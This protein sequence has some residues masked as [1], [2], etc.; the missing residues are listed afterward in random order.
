MRLRAQRGSALLLWLAQQSVNRKP[1]IIVV[2]AGIGGLTTT[3]CLQKNGYKV[4]VYEQV[5]ELSEIGA[6]IQTSANAGVVLHDLGLQE[7]LERGSNSP[8]TWYTRL[9][10]T[11]EIVKEIRL[12]NRHEELHGV[13]YYLLHRA[14]F[15]RMLVRKVREHD[16]DA[17]V[18]SASA[19]RIEETPLSISG[20]L[21][22]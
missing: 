14:D 15:H 19:E 13:P 12:G 8:L 16:P 4:K 11:D 2:G 3:A 22:Q 20:E 17:I 1:E 18:S 6:G 9:H 10:D 21:R 7:Q 5:A